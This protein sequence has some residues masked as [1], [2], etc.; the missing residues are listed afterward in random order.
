MEMNSLK[1]HIILCSVLLTVLV[2]GFAIKSQDVSAQFLYS[3]E[4]ISITTTPKYPDPGAPV[5]IRV[6][7]TEVGVE[8]SS[9]SWFINGRLQESGLGKTLFKFNAGS[10]GSVYN[11]KVVV[12]NSSGHKFEKTTSVIPSVIDF[13]W[14][15]STYTPP[16]YKGKALAGRK[17]SIKIV[18]MP[19][20]YNSSGVVL[21]DNQLIYE[22]KTRRGIS[23]SQ[24]GL[25]RNSFEFN[26]DTISVPTP[27]TLILSDRNGNTLSQKSTFF[28]ITEPELLFYENDP[29]LGI[30]FNKTLDES[31]APKN[32][33]LVVEAYPYF[34]S[35]TDRKNLALSYNWTINGETIS[36]NENSPATVTLGLGDRQSLININLSVKN[37]QNIY[38]GI[39]KT[40]TIRLDE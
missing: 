22:W 18:A 29:L 40:L 19:Q 13:L 6:V 16:L 24:S 8:G 27:I 39:K 38:E 25:G 2:F 23:S 3:D 17:A 36:L 30:L 11:I 21:N 35:K 32:R 34:F 28:E 10:L 20:T 4:A 1:K 33:E 7:S 12:E 14:E 26:S 9:I 37:I 15:A 31:F 5:S